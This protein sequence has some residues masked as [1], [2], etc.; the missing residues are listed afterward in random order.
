MV[1]STDC[2]CLANWP[3]FVQ[4]FL[5]SD[6]KEGRPSTEQFQKKL[7]WF[8]DALPSA[9]CAKGGHGAYTSS[10]DLTGY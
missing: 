7:P 9:D 5:Q 10:L 6:L 2:Y 3:R 4:C 8:L 1:L